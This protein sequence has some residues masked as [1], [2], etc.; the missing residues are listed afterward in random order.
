MILNLEIEKERKNKNWYHYEW[1]DFGFDLALYKATYLTVKEEESCLFKLIKWQIVITPLTRH[2]L[3]KP[4]SSE[5]LCLEISNR[6]ESYVGRCQQWNIYWIFIFILMRL[7]IVLSL[8]LISWMIPVHHI[9]CK[10]KT[11]VL[12]ED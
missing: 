5:V 10:M 1:R 3:P 4:D 9:K 7:E 8:E 2:N 11:V 6:C 12:L